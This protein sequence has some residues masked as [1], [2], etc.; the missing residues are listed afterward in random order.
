M[1]RIAGF[2]SLSRR[3]TPTNVPLV[4]RP[5]TKWVMR[6]AVC[7]QISLAVRVVVGLP[8]C[9]IA[10]LVGI[11]IFLGIGR[12]NLLHAA[13]RAI[14]GF[15]AG[16]DDQ[17]RAKR[18]E[19]AFAFVRGA[20]GEAELYGITR[21]RSDHGV[22][23]SS[24]ATGGIDD[25]LARAQSAARETRLNHAQC[26]AIFDGAS[27]IEP[28]G[29]G[30]ELDVGEFAADAFEPKEWAVT[31]EVENGAPDCAGKRASGG[32]KMLGGDRGH[33]GPPL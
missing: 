11:E 4:P 2:S 31:D 24:V 15:V 26:G 28:L 25:G 9:G 30:G 1:K 5:A 32:G 27:G 13:N 23:D 8:V 29:F 3:V 33:K 18:A 6:P 21:R 14:G 16:C 17:L 19:D 10:V 22:G 12:H 7:S 20:I